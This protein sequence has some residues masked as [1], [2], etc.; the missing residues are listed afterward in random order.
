MENSGELPFAPPDAMLDVAKRHWSSMEDQGATA[1]QAFISNLAERFGLDLNANDQE[2]SESDPE[3]QIDD[4]DDWESLDPDSTLES[5]YWAT[6]LLSLPVMPKDRHA[7][8]ALEI[9]AGVIA[10]AIL[11]EEWQLGVEAP[12]E[13]LREIAKKGRASLTEMLEGNVRLALYWANRYSRG[14]PDLAQDLFQEAFEGLVRGVEKWDALRGYAFSTYTSWHIRQRIQRGLD[15]PA[16]TTPVHIPVHV[17]ESQRAALRAGEEPNALGNRALQWQNER[18][19]WELIEEEVPDLISLLDPNPIEEATERIC[20]ANTVGQ[21][22][23]YL[24]EREADILVRRFGL[25]D[26]PETLDSIGEHYGISR[27]RIRQLETKALIGLR[28]HIASL[29]AY[30]SR[31]VNRLNYRDRRLAEQARVVLA[32]RST[33]LTSMAKAL[34]MSTKDAEVVYDAIVQA[35]CSLSPSLSDLPRIWITPS[36]DDPVMGGITDFEP[37]VSIK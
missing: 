28:L 8:C 17:L 16:S 7:S 9:E 25:L 19:S 3:P 11:D 5:A 22:L 18:I 33:T 26:E 6:S 1:T 20:I 35:L 27:E 31:I 30:A 13:A 29:D 15:G 32:M 2:F 34:K 10:Q 12:Y 23:A 14:N 21:C 4:V 36:P 37:R 24:S